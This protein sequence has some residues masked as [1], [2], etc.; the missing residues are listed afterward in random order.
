MLRPEYGTPHKPQVGINYSRLAQL[1]P[2]G[3]LQQAVTKVVTIGRRL[4]DGFADDGLDAPDVVLFDPAEFPGGW[5]L[6]RRRGGGCWRMLPRGAQRQRSR[7]QLIRRAVPA[8]ILSD[9][10][11]VAEGLPPY[12]TVLV[13]KFIAGK[14]RPHQVEG[15]SLPLASAPWERPM[16]AVRGSAAL[17]LW[18]QAWAA[19]EL[20]R[21]VPARSSACWPSCYV[22]PLSRAPCCLQVQFMFKCL[23]GLKDPNFRGCIQVGTTCKS[24]QGGGC[25]CRPEHAAHRSVH[26]CQ[27]TVW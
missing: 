15:V 6:G 10:P 8:P 9:L 21:W 1:G 25:S 5:V 27:P 18:K 2:G 16:L 22:H 14:L 11:P 17:V 24:V 20:G 12:A 23:A 3:A 26:V 13:D 4:G 7:W 19:P